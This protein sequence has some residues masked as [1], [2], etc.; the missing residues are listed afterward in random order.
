MEVWLDPLVAMLALALGIWML[1]KTK[2]KPKQQP[3]PAT[4]IMI[5]SGAFSKSPYGSR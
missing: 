5:A 1:R 3:K 4:R 2:P